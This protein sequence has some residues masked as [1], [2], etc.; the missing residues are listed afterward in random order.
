MGDLKKSKVMLAEMGIDVDH[1]K[2]ISETILNANASAASLN[3]SSTSVGGGAHIP[4]APQ[5][6]AAKEQALPIY[7]V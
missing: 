5:S 6:K 4:L 3:R 2:E 7:V 1:L